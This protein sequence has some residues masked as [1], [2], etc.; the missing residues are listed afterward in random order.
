MSEIDGVI[1]FCK[2]AASTLGK[3]AGSV[4]LNLR[5]FSDGDADDSTAET[6]SEETS[7]AGV[8]L[9]SNP[10]PAD[11]AGHAEAVALRAE[12]GLPTIALR[13][14]RITKA[15]GPIAK[16]A[17]SLAGYGGAFL[18]IDDAASGTG[19]V[20]TLYVPFEH[21]GAGVPAKAHVLTIDSTPGNEGIVLA[22]ADGHAL[23][24]TPEGKV[25]LKNKAGDAFLSIEEEGLVFSGDL[26][27]TNNLLAGSAPAVQPLLVSVAPLAWAAQVQAAIV[28]IAGLLNA[29]GP[30]SGAPASVTVPIPVPS[31]STWTTKKVQGEPG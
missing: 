2:V 14:L 18:T 5:A 20:V 30:V 4:L 17:V 6:S 15:R 22:H 3:G 29:P 11:A 1:A 12:D 10:R 31:P 26:K 21:D 7:Y 8:G 25:L 24:L 9:I 27:V 16:G 13:D 23:L 19:S 28:A